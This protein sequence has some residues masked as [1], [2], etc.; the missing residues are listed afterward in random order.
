MGQ[1]AMYSNLKIPWTIDCYYDRE[2]LEII[3]LH[4]LSNDRSNMIAYQDF[5]FLSIIKKL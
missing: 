4:W 3:N 5:Y 1:V 2:F